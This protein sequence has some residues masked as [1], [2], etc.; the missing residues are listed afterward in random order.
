[1]FWKYGGDG[2]TRILG[3]ST[4]KPAALHEYTHFSV[5]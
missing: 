3:M 4:K 5:L 1:M 2:I